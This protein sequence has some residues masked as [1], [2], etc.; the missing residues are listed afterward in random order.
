MCLKFNTLP[1]YR[2]LVELWY[3]FQVNENIKIFWNLEHTWS[4]KSKDN[5][6]PSHYA[7]LNPIVCIR[8]CILYH[9]QSKCT[10]C[11]ISKVNHPVDSAHKEHAWVYNGP[12]RKLSRALFSAIFYEH[13]GFSKAQQR[14][15]SRQ[16]LQII[17][18][19]CT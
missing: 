2:T 1:T 17:S 4:N 16:Q 18:Q 11:L 6:Y 15:L 8:M 13:E 5:D 10:S 9:T 19:Q 14:T 3:A 12:F 7:V